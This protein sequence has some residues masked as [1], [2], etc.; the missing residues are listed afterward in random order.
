[1]EDNNALS[2][3]LSTMETYGWGDIGTGDIGTSVD[4][5]HSD[6]M[7]CD[8]VFGIDPFYIEKGDILNHC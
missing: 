1:M 3:K 4:K 2:A 8:N 7:Q 5:S 6:D